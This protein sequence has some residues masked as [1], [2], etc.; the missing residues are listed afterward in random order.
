MKA[1]SVS[2]ENHRPL[3]GRLFPYLLLLMISL[4]ILVL[5]LDVY[6]AAWFDEGYSMHAARNLAERNMY[7]TYS[8][9]EYR[10]FDSTITTGPSVIIPIALSFKLFGMGMPQARLVIILFTLLALFSL[11]SISVHIYGRAAAL[12]IVMVLLAM[13]A[14]QDVSF[15]L[16]G[17]QVLGE[18]PSLALTLFGLW[19]WLRSWENE[20][21][22]LSLL[23]GLA[24]GLGLISKMQVGIALLPTLV[25]TAIGRGLKNH[26]RV[27]KLLAPTAVML[28]VGGSWMLL[29]RLGANDQVRQENNL[30]LLEAV[31]TNMLTRLF[32]RGL[33]TSALVILAIIGVGVLAGGWRLRGQFLGT[34]PSTNA[35]WTEAAIVLFALCSALW[36]AFLSIGWPRYAYAGLIAGQ[37]LFGKL[38]WDMFEYIRRWISGRWPSFARLAY[39]IAVVGLAF[40]A[41]LVNICPVLWFKQDYQAQQMANYISAEIPRDAVIE[42]WEWELDALS[43]HWEYHHPHQRYLFLAIRQLF[44]EQKPFD[45]DYDLLQADPDYLVAGPFS[46]WT[47]I[48]E[49]ELVETSFTEIAEIGAYRIY[50]RI[51]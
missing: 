50:K 51:R 38:S 4:P 40:I 3:I 35:D 32:G 12:F 16:T 49:S 14:I 41:I 31:S 9:P 25:L 21:W 33:S 18:T 26:S 29:G 43:S 28:L 15:L 24:F 47:R 36:F 10:P 30:M 44:H 11:F 13:P 22:L 7:G 34:R 46:D 5:R 6:P 39:T 23:A 17:R 2:G 45:L 48:Y 19:L 27:I 37:L 20:H 42:S 8:T 1:L